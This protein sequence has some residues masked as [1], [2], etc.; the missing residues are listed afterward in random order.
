MDNLQDKNNGQLSAIESNP[1]RLK[2]MA[3]FPPKKEKII[4]AYDGSFFT[5]P[6]KEQ[7]NLKTRISMILLS[8]SMFM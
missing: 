5:F 3:G 6:T 8:T 4:S 7:L 1:N 2:W